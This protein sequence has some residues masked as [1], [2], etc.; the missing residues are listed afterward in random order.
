MIFFF[1][2]GKNFIVLIKV[3][4]MMTIPKEKQ[5]IEMPIL[6]L[7]FYYSSVLHQDFS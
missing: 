1:K 6:Y 4:K 3:R 2:R 7:L 5:V